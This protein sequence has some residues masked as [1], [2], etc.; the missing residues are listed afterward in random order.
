[1]DELHPLALIGLPEEAAFLAAILDD[2]A[3][4][5]PRL[6][7]ADW[8]EDHDRHDRAEFIRLQCFYARKPADDSGALTDCYEWDDLVRFYWERI[9]PDLAARVAAN[10]RARELSSADIEVCFPNWE[11]WSGVDAMKTLDVRTHRGFPGWVVA[12]DLPSLRQGLEGPLRVSPLTYLKIRLN[13]PEELEELLGLGILGQ[14]TEL[15]LTLAR[16]GGGE[17]RPG[18]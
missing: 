15:R 12:D 6:V 16:Q 10:R 11:N 8:L 9:A 13:S 14:L 5:T 17:F 1:V 4:D 7:Y 18:R 2:P 3:D